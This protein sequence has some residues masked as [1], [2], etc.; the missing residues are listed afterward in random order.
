MVPLL[1]EVCRKIILEHM[2]PQTIWEVY[3]YSV[4][5]GDDFLRK[6]CREYFWK[7]E[8]L[9]E[10]A[11]ALPD[12]LNIPYEVLLE[13]LQLNDSNFKLPWEELQL[14]ILIS[15]KELFIAC[16]AWAVEECKRRNILISG[17]NKKKVLG[18]C[19]KLINFRSMASNDITNIVLPTEILNEK[20]KTSL[21]VHSVAMCMKKAEDKCL[22]SKQFFSVDINQVMD[23]RLVRAVNKIEQHPNLAGRERARRSTVHVTP[24]KRLILSQIWLEPREYLYERRKGNETYHGR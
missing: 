2:S 17:P 20:Q 1:E 6:G 23:Q 24:N 4:T 12:F 21:I 19:L 5:F 3:S 10:E 15:E 7:K 13:V 16:H 11:L 8:M 14:G 9:F 22:S 18:K